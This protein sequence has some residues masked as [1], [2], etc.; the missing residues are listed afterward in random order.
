VTKRVRL[1]RR[2]TLKDAHAPSGADV[3]L[4][5]E[6]TVDDLIPPNLLRASC[7]VVVNGRVVGRGS[8][9]HDGDRVELFGQAAGG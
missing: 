7:L 2:G 4:P 9:V 5:D 3:E 8:A 6:A 1:I